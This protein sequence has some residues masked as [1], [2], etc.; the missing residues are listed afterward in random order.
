MRTQV[1]K[2]GNS[3]G[4]IIP[5]S[6]IRQLGLTEGAEIDIR[7]EGT[8]ITI[9]PVLSNQKRLPLSEKELLKGLNAQTA[10]ADG[11]AALSD[12]EIGE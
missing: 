2:I 4:N 1:R 5:A 12:R 6:L 7:M 10:H 9:E 3:L 8:K 11:L